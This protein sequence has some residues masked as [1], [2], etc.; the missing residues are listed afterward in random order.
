MKELPFPENAVYIRPLTKDELAGL[1]DVTEDEPCYG[2]FDL[3]GDMVGACTSVTYAFE[4][5]LEDS[6]FPQRL[7]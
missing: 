3:K 4:A 1:D 2:I 5:C 6:V 7:N